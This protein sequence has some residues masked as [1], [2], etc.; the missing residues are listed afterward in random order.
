[1]GEKEASENGECEET[2]GAPERK[3]GEKKERRAKL[4]APVKSKKRQVA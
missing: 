1:V 2:Q 4:Q 3:E